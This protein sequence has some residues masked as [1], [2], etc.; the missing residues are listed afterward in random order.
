MTSARTVL[1]VLSGLPGSGKT[2]VARELARQTGAVHLRVDTIEHAIASSRRLGGPV[3]ELGY[4][5]AYAIAGDNLRLG[6]TVIADSVNPIAVTREAWRRLAEVEGVPA[7]DVEVFC[8][9]MEEH[10]RRVETRV[11]DIE[12][13]TGPTWQE[14]IDREYD[15]WVSADIRADTATT[16]VDEIVTQVR[17]AIAE[18]RA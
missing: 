2:T 16:P 1:V 6:N 17:D 14:V 7:V 5:L 11:P 4:R 9:D 15:P 18:H 8:S 10:R 13:F 3:N 12:G